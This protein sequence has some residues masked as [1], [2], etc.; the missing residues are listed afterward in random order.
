[1]ASTGTGERGIPPNRQS[2]GAVERPQARISSIRRKT[3]T[4]ASRQ[5][6]MIPSMKEREGGGEAFMAHSPEGGK[7]V[8]VTSPQRNMAAPK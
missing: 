4:L 5:K 2:K 3:T 8:R 6:R 7:T 1:M